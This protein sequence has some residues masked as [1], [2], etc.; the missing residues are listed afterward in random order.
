MIFPVLLEV[1]EAILI[2]AGHSEDFEIEDGGSNE[3]DNFSESMLSK[4][5]AF[6][7]DV[8]EGRITVEEA[9]ATADAEANDDDPQDC[10]VC[11]IGH[12][13]TPAWYAAT[14][15]PSQLAFSERL[16]GQPLKHLDVQ[17]G[18]LIDD[19]LG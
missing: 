10:K 1:V 12:R 17:P 16:S 6:E 3:F 4:V 13:S 15:W 9:R 18:G 7:R 19:A 14:L 11:P 8:L 5:A 2:F